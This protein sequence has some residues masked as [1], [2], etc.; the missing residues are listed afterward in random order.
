[1]VVVTKK[2]FCNLNF[3]HFNTQI[4]ILNEI[5]DIHDDM[6]VKAIL[7]CTSWFSLPSLIFDLKWGARWN[8]QMLHLYEWR[9][10]HR[11]E[12]NLARLYLI[13]SCHLPLSQ[14][15]S[16]SPV[17]PYRLSQR[18][19]HLSGAVVGGGGHLVPRSGGPAHLEAAGHNPRPPRVCQVWGGARTCQVGHGK[20]SVVWVSA[21]LDVDVCTWSAMLDVICQQYFSLIYWFIYLSISMVF[22][23]TQLLYYILF[24]L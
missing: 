18:P 13:F 23:S 12:H 14:T 22:Q 8:K 20:W 19:G 4:A 15:L 10:W 7:R 21:C 5:L 17:P 3:L 9:K 11:E 2:I 1:M 6:G 16:L 24:I